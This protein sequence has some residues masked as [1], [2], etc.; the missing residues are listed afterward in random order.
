MRRRGRRGVGEAGERESRAVGQCGRVDGDKVGRGGRGLNGSCGP[1][2]AGS[3]G[4]GS[5]WAVSSKSPSDK[6]ASSDQ[7]LQSEVNRL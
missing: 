6:L 4:A 3:D 2:G 7:L 1:C 5:C